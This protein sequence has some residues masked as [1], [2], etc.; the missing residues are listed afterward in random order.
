ML[1]E[2]G[3]LLDVDYEAIEGKS[4]IR[5]F[6]KTIKGLMVF[7][8]L[9]FKPYFYAVPAKQ[10][11]AESL[12][13]KLAEARFENIKAAKAEVVE[14]AGVGKAIKLSFDSTLD[15][16]IA[17]KGV[18][19]FKGI[20]ER[21]EYD[22]LFHHRYLLDKSLK[23]MAV[24][25]I[26][27][28]EINGLKGVKEARA[29][30]ELPSMNELNLL[31]LDIETSNNFIDGV[32]HGFST[33]KKNHVTFIALA[34][35][36]KTVLTWNKR[37]EGVKWI[38]VLPDEW[39]LVNK[40]NE[41][42]KEKQVDLLLTYNGDGFDIPFLDERARVLGLKL[43]LSVD[44]S[45]AR[46]SRHGMT[47]RAD[48]AGRLH[49][50]VFKMIL[51]LNRVNAVNLS[52]MDLET[53][54]QAVFK[55]SKPDFDYKKMNEVWDKGSRDDLLEL[56]EYNKQD[57]MA[58]LRLGREFMPLFVEVS[59]LVMLPLNEVVRES[60]GALVDRMLF[61]KANQRNE[62]IPN[63]P[64]EEAIS[65]RQ[66]NVFKGAF[67]KEPLPGIHENLAVLDYKSFHPSIIISHN[68]GFDSL[69]CKCCRDD[70]FK[71]LNEVHYC[72]NKKSLIAE[73]CEEVMNARV[74]EKAKLKNFKE[75]TPEYDAAFSKQYALKIIL[76]SIY[77]FIGHAR[78]RWYSGK[79]MESI[80][81]FVRKYILDTIEFFEKNG[82]QVVYSDTDS[83]V[84]K[85]PEGKSRQELEAL[86]KEN[87]AVLPKPMELELDKYYKRGIFVT[88]KLAVEKTSGA[89]KKYAL[90]DEKGLMKIVGFEYVRR[91][92]CG[93]ARHTQKK[94]L[95]IVLKE[96][97]KNKA[98]QLVKKTMQDL[99]EG[100]TSK[101]D[102]IILTQIQKPLSQYES[103]GPHVA[104]ALKAVK[105][106]KHVAKGMMVEFIITKQG[107]SISDKA[108]LEEFVQ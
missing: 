36:E 95:E 83:A 71:A 7:H 46:L 76:N 2:K 105:Q 26:G 40:L 98:L 29:L 5:L 56:A 19:F 15:L 103:T 63:K 47:S 62:L 52:K 54:Y 49:V 24:V 87:N 94:L 86:V 68:I 99:K 4:V 64:E 38:K 67:V 91:D 45:D 79:V 107:K 53:A 75:G 20:K 58:A 8:D 74:K 10:E 28:E 32:D 61:I 41:T 6:V 44:G 73:V 70:G 35:E 12:M 96:G 69:D 27:F 9:E 84:I 30:D 55:E 65:A 50:D 72:R 17:R 18:K 78:S 93:L 48:L 60:T 108:F 21:R 85:I 39:N 14:K 100:K 81:A 80:Y 34:G 22:I 92:W 33:P 42:V 66:A 104:A 25:E 82:F 43:D 88:K 11:E 16:T 77:G 102:L 23:P 1:K 57:A 37:L 13:E 51:F 31:A 3:L 59:K 101:K 90:I 97:D 89:K 106:G